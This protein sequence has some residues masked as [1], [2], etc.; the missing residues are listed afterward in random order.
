VRI[1]S[2]RRSGRYSDTEGLEIE[3]RGPDSAEKRAAALAIE[4]LLDGYEGIEDAWTSNDGRRDEFE[5]ALKPRAKELEI[6]ERGLA[7]QIRHVEKRF[8]E[9]EVQ[10]FQVE[11]EPETT[12]SDIMTTPD[13]QPV[14][15]LVLKRSVMLMKNGQP[16][17][18]DMSTIGWMHQFTTGATVQVAA[19]GATP[20]S[21]G[22][23]GSPL[24]ESM[25]VQTLD[26]DYKA[27]FAVFPVGMGSFDVESP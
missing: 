21:V 9:E 7:T 12:V 18:S 26:G 17:T 19:Q 20:I 16:M 24:C 1:S 11:E 23:P 2:K 3:L 27:S 8:A 4:T 22:T 14:L 6:T 25:G 15:K 10:R 5:I 13:G